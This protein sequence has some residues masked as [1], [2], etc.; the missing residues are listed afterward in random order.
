[1]RLS[2]IQHIPKDMVDHAFKCGKGIDQAEGYNRILEEAV[3]ASE[4]RFPPIA[5]L[6][7]YRMVA[8]TS[9]WDSQSPK[10]TTQFGL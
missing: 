3:A 2:F 1:M 7:P 5:L 9:L 10:A 6:D 4:R 8:V